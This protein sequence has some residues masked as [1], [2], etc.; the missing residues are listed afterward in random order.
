MITSTCIFNKPI[1]KIFYSFI[2]TMNKFT[3]HWNTIYLNLDK[4]KNNKNDNK[5]KRIKG[6]SNSLSKTDLDTFKNKKIDA[7][8]S[9][10]IIQGRNSKK[11]TQKQ[12]AQI[13]NV[14]PAVINEYESGKAMPNSA[15][16]NK[17][18]RTLGI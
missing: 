2:T 15:I 8:F 11:L 16:L 14:K 7:G 10:K 18:K 17:L 6:P 9:K 3:I 4:Y 12:L 1:F 5:T 13:I